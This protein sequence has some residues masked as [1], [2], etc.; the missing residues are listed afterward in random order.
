MHA[1]ASAFGVEIKTSFDLDAAASH[2]SLPAVRGADWTLGLLALHLYFCAAT[3]VRDTNTYLDRE[4]I[5]ILHT[6]ALKIWKQRTE[7]LRIGEK[8]KHLFR[9]ALHR[10]I[11]GEGDGHSYTP[12]AA[13]AEM[14]LMMF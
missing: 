13:A 12:A 8:I 1:R 10:E 3:N 6:H 4:M 14:A 7:A 9:L 5:G 2:A 11:A